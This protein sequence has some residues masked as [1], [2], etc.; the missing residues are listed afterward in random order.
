MKITEIV[1]IIQNEEAESEKKTDR[2][3]RGAREGRCKLVKLS[4][5]LLVNVILNVNL[6]RGIRRVT[7]SIMVIISRVLLIIVG[8]VFRF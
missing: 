8:V 1:T 6:R 7:A 4:R 2:R 3:G 5:V